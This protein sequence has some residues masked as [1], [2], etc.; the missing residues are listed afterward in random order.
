MIADRQPADEEL[1]AE[2]VQVN[3]AVV[4]TVVE[5]VLEDVA[6]DVA[7]VATPSPLPHGIPSPPQEPSSPPQQPHVTPPAPTQEHDNVTQRLEIVNLKARVKKLEK[8][9]KNK[10]SKLSRFRKVGASRQVKSSDDIEDVFNQRRM[11]NEDEG[12]ELEVVEVVTTAKLITKVVTTAA[13]Q[14]SAASTTIFAASATIPA[15]KPTISSAAPTVVAAYT[16]KRKGVIIRDLK[17]ELSLKTSETPAETPKVK[18]K[19]KGIMVEAPKPM[20]KKNQIEMDA[21]YARKLFD[22]NIRFLFK[23]RE[24][25]E[26]ED[27]EIIK[28]INETPAQKA[29]KRRKLSEEAQE[30]EDLRKRLEVVDD[31]DDDVFV[32]ATPLASKLLELMLLK[33]SKKNTKCVSAANEELTAAKHNLKLKLFKDA[34]AV[35]HAKFVPS[36]GYHAIPPPV[37]GTFMPSKPELVFHTPPSDENEHLAFNVQLGPT[38]PEQDLSSRP[39]APPV[40]LRTHS[41][42]KGSRRTKKTCFSKSPLRR[43]FTRHPSSKPSISHPRVTAAKP[44]AVSAAQNNHGKWNNDEDAAFD[45]NEPDFDAKNHKSEVNVS[46][47]SSAQ[48]RKQDDKTKKEAKGKSHVES[49]T[50]YRNLSAEF[51][52]YSNNIINEVNAADSLLPI[53]FWAEAVNT[54]CYVQNRVL[55]T[56]P[57]NKTPYELLHGRTQS[58]GFTRPFDC[59]VTILNTLDSLVKFDG[60]VDEGFLVGYYNNDEDVAFDEKEHDAKKPESKVNVS[61]N[62][63]TQDLSAEFEDCFENSSN[64]VNA[65]GKFQRKVDEGFLVGYSICSKAFRVFNSRN[66]IVQETLHVNFMEN[67]PNVAGSGP[68]WL[69]DIDSLSQIMNYHPVLAENQTNSNAGFQDTEKKSV[70]LDI[71]SSSCGDQT[72]EQGEKAE[73]KDKE[74]DT[75]NME[76]IILVSPIPTT[77][78][79]KDHPTSQIIGDLSLTT[80]TI[81]MARAVRDQEEPKRVHQALKDPSW[82]EA[83]QEELLQFKMQKVWILVD[84]PYGKRAIGTKWVYRNKKDERGIVIRNKARLVAQEHTQE[85]FALVARIEAIRLFLAYASFMGFP[86]YQMDVKSAFL[87]GTIEEEVYVKAGEEI[88][89]QYVLFSVWSSGSTSPQNSDEDAAFDEKEPDFDAKKPESEV[90][91]SPSSSAQS[92]KQDDKT[93][94]R[95][96]A[97]VNSAGTQVLTVGQNSPNST[98]TFSAAG[99]LNVAARPT[100]GKSSFID[101]SQLPDDPDMPELEDI[102]YSNDEDDVGAEANFNNLET[103][104]TTSPILIIRVHKDHHVIQIISDLSSTT[105]IRSMTRV[106][107]DQGGLSQMLNDDFYTCIAVGTKWVFKN[108]KDERGIVVRNKARLVAQGHTHKDG[109]DYE[110]V[111]APVVRIESIRLFLAY[112]SFMGFM[113]YQMDVKS[114]FLYGTIEEEVYVCQPPGF[115]D[116]DHPDKVYKVVKALYGLHQAPRAWKF[117]LTKGKS[118]STFIDTEKPLLKGPDGEDVD[119]NTYRSMIGSLMYLTSSILDIMFAVCACARFQVTSKA[120]HLHAVK[121]IFRLISWQCKKQTVVATSS[122]KA[123]YVVAASYCAQVLW[124][125][126]QLLDYGPKANSS[127]KD[128][129]NPLIVDSLLK[130]IWSSIHH[131]IIN[132][133]LT[134]PGQTTTGKEI[135][136]PFMDGVNTPRCEEDRIEL[137]ELT[138]F[139]LQKVEKLELELVLLTTG[140]CCQAYVTVAA[141]TSGSAHT[142][143]DA[144][145]TAG[146]HSDTQEPA[147]EATAKTTKRALFL[148]ESTTKCNK[149]KDNNALFVVFAVASLAGRKFNFFKYIFN[150]LVR[151][152][153]SPS[154]FYMY[155]GFLQLMIRKQVSDLSTH[156]TKYTSS[157]LTQKVFANIKRV[158]KGFYGVET[159]LFEGMLVEQQVVEEGDVDENDK[160]IN[161]GDA[162]ESDV[163]AA[164]GEVLTVAEQPSIP[165][166]TPPTSPPKPSQDI[167]STSQAQPTPPQSPQVQPPSPQ[168]QSQPQPQQEARIPMH[169]FQEKVGTTQRVETSNET[170]MDDV[171]SQGRMIAE[172][173]VGADVVLEDDKEVADEAKDVAED[174]KINESVEIQERTAESHAKIYKIDL[175]HTNKVLSMQEDETE[176]AKVQE[177]VDVVTAAKLVTE[178]VTAA[179]ET[180]T[181]ASTNITAAEAQ[182]LT[183]TLIATPARVNA[184]PSRRKKGVELEAELNRNIDWDEAIDHVKK[185]AKEDPAVKRYQ[186]LKRKP[187]TEAQVRKN[188]IVYLKNVVGFKMDYFKGMSY[189]DICPVFEKYFDSNVAFLIK[190]KE[191]MDDEESRALKRLNETPAEK[192][193]KKQKLD[194]EVEELKRHLQI[195]PNEDDDVYT[196]A[197]PFA[198]KVPVVDYEII[199]LN[200]KPYYKIIRADAQRSVYEQAKVKSWKLLESCGVQITKFTTTQLILLVERKY[201]LTKFTLDQM[202][203]AVRLEVEEEREVSLELLRFIRQQFQEGAQLE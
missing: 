83:M 14:V 52:D 86:V 37:S 106:A 47:S 126:N 76:S 185:K 110:E 90:I 105:Q 181:A 172:V 131:L 99:P 81:S 176:P 197:I 71:H 155:P 23:S 144:S 43:P 30:A 34:A 18:D 116:P 88:D 151:N 199:E 53:P 85:V 112:A 67:K 161:A 195:V 127:G 10:S 74:A 188:M 102:T 27:Q 22:E 143:T 63:S 198:R 183:V 50:G 109:I 58:I 201:P 33:R 93:K 19:G 153:D 123:E 80:Q 194:A 140:F 162:A 95:L 186:V 128:R 92:K 4:A 54:A 203:N 115:E 36:G 24:E 60:K 111:F 135:S 41:P 121:R 48:S 133:V 157:A 124:I 32:E 142:I 202:L 169:L 114:V 119:V 94:K 141:G 89:Q 15:A 6:E 77:R 179:S 138:G 5:D 178:V 192:E 125:Q 200:N 46:P 87:Y 177:V 56:K 72:R 40:P 137:M 160:N 148:E 75:N 166:P 113:V 17:E 191:Q 44:S 8:T 180:I 12:I 139:L 13:S 103:S 171:S 28:S 65:A 26:E 29:A 62:S 122:T 132:E 156:T 159:P 68:A 196:E 170:M 66:R 147:N 35:A 168:H 39:I 149:R 82:I 120:S 174:A 25:M 165:S 21:E 38:K 152:I 150:S 1:G 61:P 31:E 100:H 154:K 3:A 117:R 164:H 69:F 101:A 78:I 57:H 136:N 158:G 84:L 145:T 45:G 130:T 189:D 184:A 79:H 190:S 51:E 70:S 107:K 182:V 55:V 7:H 104:I 11:M 98:N 20:K 187:Q 9:D 42:S 2:Q 108:K 146:Q 129:S 16:R 175:D 49:F 163:S 64:E 118:A 173:D 193:A 134:I 73:N 91:V 96:K 167:P 59:H 97:R